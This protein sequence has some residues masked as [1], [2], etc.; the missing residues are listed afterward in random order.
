V[1]LASAATR[2]AEVSSEGNLSATGRPRRAGM[3]HPMI[4]PVRTAL[5]RIE[6]DVIALCRVQCATAHLARTSRCQPAHDALAKCDPHPRLLGKACSEHLSP[7][8]GSGH[9]GVTLGAMFARTNAAAAR[10]GDHATQDH[11]GV[12]PHIGQP[13]GLHAARARP[14]A[15]LRSPRPD[16]DISAP[17]KRRCRRPRYITEKLPNNAALTRR[18]AL[19]M[20]KTNDRGQQRAR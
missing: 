12:S 11:A 14:R 10:A 7:G 19:L 2:S 17:A 20:I 6:A 13:N 8:L 4:S 18:Q 16:W 3:T 5:D 9:S 1:M 15:R